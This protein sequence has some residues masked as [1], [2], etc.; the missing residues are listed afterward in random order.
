MWLNMPKP[1]PLPSGC[2]WIKSDSL[3]KLRIMDAAWPIWTNRRP[4]P[5]T[6]CATCENA[7]KMSV[8]SS[9][10]APPPK[11]D[12]SCASP[13]RSGAQ[14]DKMKKCFQTSELVIPQAEGGDVS[15]EL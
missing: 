7:W 9:Q 1:Q 5:E 2:G 13:P 11:A 3:W 14:M 10:S 4:G 15:K 6:D 12:Q 8:A